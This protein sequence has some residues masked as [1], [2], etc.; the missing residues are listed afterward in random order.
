MRLK[1]EVLAPMPSAME[2]MASA[3]KPGFFTSWRKP[4]R[5]SCRSVSIGTEGF[6][7]NGC[8][9][10]PVWIQEISWELTT[11]CADNTDR[12]Q[13][14]RKTSVKI[15]RAGARPAIQGTSLRQA[16][17]LP[18]NCCRKQI[19]T[20]GRVGRVSVTNI[21]W[22]MN[23]CEVTPTKSSRWTT[24]LAYSSTDYPDRL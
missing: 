5:I 12:R 20:S 9:S 22:A 17:R 18:Y 8:S 7:L 1:I 3:A 4:N 16:E 11:N 2:M 21:L 13:D 14:H 19:L 15:C 6:C 10:D 24:N 23:I